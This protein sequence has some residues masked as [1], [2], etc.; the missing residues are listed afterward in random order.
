MGLGYHRW[1]GLII[2][3]VIAEEDHGHGD[4]GD[5]EDRQE[6]NEQDIGLGVA[7]DVGLCQKHAGKPRKQG[8]D[9]SAESGYQGDAHKNTG[10]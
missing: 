2:V 5:D 10:E 6:D 9:D 1:G 4:G 7:T 8:A 3:A